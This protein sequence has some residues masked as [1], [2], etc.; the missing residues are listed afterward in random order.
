MKLIIDEEKIIDLLET[1]WGYEGIRE[2]VSKLLRE[3]GIPYDDSGDCISRSA[4]RE[5]IE[6]ST[7]TII[8]YGKAIFL[9][10]VNELIHNAPAVEYTG[11][12]VLKEED[13]D[14]GGNNR[15]ECTNCHYSDVHAGSAEVPYCWHCGAEM[16]KGGAE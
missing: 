14:D 15:Y 11:E 4:L 12:W 2:E 5:E 6:K 8:G 13:C 1:E 3:N 9:D 10:K 16:Q 7:V